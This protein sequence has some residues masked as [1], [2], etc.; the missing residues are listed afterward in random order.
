MC[1]VDLLRNMIAE[2]P[3]SEKAAA[4]TGDYGSDMDY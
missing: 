3:K 2:Q 4:P 1:Q